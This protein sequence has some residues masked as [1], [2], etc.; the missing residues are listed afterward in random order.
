MVLTRTGRWTWREHLQQVELIAIEKRNN[1]T[2]RAYRLDNE[3]PHYGELRDW[4]QRHAISLENSVPHT[5]HMNG[6]A[7]RGFRTDRE[8][9]SA[10]LQ[11]ATN[12]VSTTI[13]KILGTR[14]EEAMR[15][16]SLSETLWVE[17]F[18][19]AIWIKNRSPSRALEGKITPWEAFYKLKPSLNVERIFGSRVYITYPPEH[20]RKSLLQARGWLGYFV[21][22]ETEAVLRIWH[23]EKKRVVRVTAPR[24]DDGQGQTDNHDGE[25]L[26]N[27]VPIGDITLNDDT[28]DD[29]STLGAPPEPHANGMKSLTEPTQPEREVSRYSTRSTSKISPYFAQAI[30]NT[31]RQSMEMSDTQEHPHS[32]S[33]S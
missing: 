31:V 12:S 19:H 22:F 10:M 7:E 17:A 21:G 27:R 8:R 25:T 2:I 32:D 20:R 33:Q 30:R 3:L 23:P 5:H 6:V 18:S 28:S 14:T 9:A 13:S 24:V 29:E 1:I 15:N 16:V 11:E 4:F 26:A